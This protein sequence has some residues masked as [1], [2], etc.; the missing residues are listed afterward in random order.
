MLFYPFSRFIF[1]SGTLTGAFTDALSPL[2]WF[3]LRCSVTQAILRYFFSSGQ[4]RGIRTT[5]EHNLGGHDV[6]NKITMSSEV[7]L[8][9]TY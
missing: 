2:V 9:L 6:K 1:H 8:R 7:K 3:V 4:A 5:H